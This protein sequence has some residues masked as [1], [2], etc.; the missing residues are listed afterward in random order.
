MEIESKQ[1]LAARFIFSI[2]ISVVIMVVVSPGQLRTARADDVVTIDFDSYP[3]GTFIAT[4]YSS[5]GVT[6]SS[7][8]PGGPQLVDNGE[9]SSPPNYLAGVDPMT[10]AGTFPIVMDLAVP[11]PNGIEV[12][13]VSVG[14]ATV[15]ATALASDLVTVLD[16]IVVTH[17]S[18]AGV[19]FG[20][21]DPIALNGVGIARVRFDITQGAVL[22][23]VGIDDVVLSPCPTM[24]ASGCKNAGKS[25]LLLQEETADHSK[26]KLLWKWIK[27]QAID[28]GELGDPTAATSYAFCVF[29]GANKLID[30][31]ELPAGDSLWSA[32]GSTGFKYSDA[33]LAHDGAKSALVKSGGAGKAKSVLKGAGVNLPRPPLGMSTLTLP[34][35]TQLINGSACLQATFDTSSVVKNTSDQFKAKE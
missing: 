30:Q 12:T 26:D 32:T 1:T 31:V 14:S 25:M 24:P 23:G 6:F 21:H 33:S 5:L 16:T 17:G 11:R 34:L 35:T 27:G 15:T 7:P 3:A 8:A 18:G 13:L 4:Q 29:D 9:A 10:E 22:D 2:L 28:I 19:G 20:N